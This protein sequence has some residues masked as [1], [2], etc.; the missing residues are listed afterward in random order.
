MTEIQKITKISILVYGIVC[1]FFAVYL[2]FF[3]DIF[4]DVVNMPDWGNP[5]H[6]RM[7]GGAMLVVVIF[8]LLIFLKKDWDREKIN[9]AYELLYFW[10]LINIITESSL[11]TIYSSELSSTALFQ[12]ILD[13]I[14]MSILLVLG[15]YSYIKQRE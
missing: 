11:L 2:I 3:F 14:I 8:A 10:L 12:N 5:Y 6:P 13:I 15:V 9:L 4:L 1:I 7:F